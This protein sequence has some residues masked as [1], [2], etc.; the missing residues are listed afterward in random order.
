MCAGYWLGKP[1]AKSPLEISRR[2]TEDNIKIHW[3]ISDL[4]CIQV[5]QDL[6]KW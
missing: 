1:E 2:R 5:A 3:K 4:D 6:E